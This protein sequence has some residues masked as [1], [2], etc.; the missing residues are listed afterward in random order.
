M[1]LYVSGASEVMAT[2]NTKKIN[3][4]ESGASTINLIGSCDN[5]DAQ[6]TGA[7]TFK[8]YKLN[9]TDAKL[10]TTRASTAKVL[11]NGRLVANANGASDIKVKGDPTEIIAE[12]TTAS[13]ITRIVE[14][15][16][17][18]VNDSMT[19]VWKKKKIIVVNG[20]DPE[21]REEDLHHSS[22]KHWRGFSMGVNGYMT[23]PG[24]INIPKKYNYMDLNYGKSYNFQLNLSEI[25]IKLAKDNVKLITGVGFDIHSYDLSHR[26]VL[27]SDSS[28]TSAYMDSTS[29]TISKN[30]FRTAFI[31]VPLLVE[32]NTSNSPDKTF[33]IAFGVIGQY[34][35]GGRTKQLIEDHNDNYKKIRKDNYN[36]SP[37]AVKAHVDFGYSAWT[38]FG[39]YSLTTLFQPGKGPE[40]YPF[41]V[42]LRVI[43]FG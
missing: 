18:A 23:S 8:A 27:N 39:E 15:N 14:P 38:F 10:T 12:S 4:H 35:L 34:L 21:K 20:T 13:S 7:S 22:F 33:H 37:F 26:S 29:R 17:K 25:Q 41:T 1:S 11:V 30:R 16:Q 24:D 31:Q 40:L 42:G 6:I 19:Y 9:V 36:L 2:I 28:Y 32:F 3:C 5:L 43:P